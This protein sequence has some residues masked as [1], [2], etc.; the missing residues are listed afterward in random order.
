MDDIIEDFLEDC[1]MQTR[2]IHS[3]QFDLSGKRVMI[4]PLYLDSAFG[5]S[6]VHEARE[7]IS[8][9]KSDFYS[10]FS[11][12]NIKML[13]KKLAQIDN[14][15]GCVV[16]STGMSAILLLILGLVQG[17][18]NEN[19]IFDKRVY[20][21]ISTM[22]SLLC[23]K[24]KLQLKMVDVSSDAEFCAALDEATRMVFIETP[25][26]PLQET[27]D[28]QQAA[29][30][31]RENAPDAKL[32]VDNTMLSPYFQDCFAGGAQLAMYSVTK[33]LAG[34]GDAM[35][36]Y[37]TGSKELISKLRRVRALFGLIMRPL[38]AWLT[39]RGLK[40]FQLRIQKQEENTDR[41]YRYLKEHPQIIKIHSTRDTGRTDYPVIRK[42]Q[43]GNGTVLLIEI[44]G[45]SRKCE[46][47]M[48]KL[49]LF[50]I[51]TTF[52]NTESI[53]YH[54]HTFFR[55]NSTGSERRENERMVRLS[56]GLEA[57]ED[58]IKDL[59]NALCAIR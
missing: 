18:G 55:S 4:P 41:I 21:E 28:I 7:S 57:V 40:T 20:H 35:G 59:D 38:D 53:V 48:G 46:T 1:D 58:L 37:I 39:L 29:E 2:I 31:M 24:M 56:I 14:V 30:K 8:K 51:A 10:R 15:E 3:G 47:F 34:H 49:K 33:H 45:D 5:F 23:R 43:N 42:Q 12:P 27:I 22:V 26:N 25:T 32:V 50:R 16:T 9:Y 17:T 44:D 13:E 19:I 6:D 52:G 11:T 36:G 54:F